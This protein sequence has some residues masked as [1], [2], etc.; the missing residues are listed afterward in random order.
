MGEYHINGNDLF[1]LSADLEEEPVEDQRMFNQIKYAFDNFKRR[2]ASI[3][4]GAAILP[5]SVLK[6]YSLPG[7]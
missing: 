2:N 7:R 4:N 6:K 3:G 5:D 1:K